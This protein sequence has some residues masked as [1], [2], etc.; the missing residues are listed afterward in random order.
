MVYRGSCESEGQWLVVGGDIKFTTFHEV[1]EVF[2][3]N[4]YCYKVTIETAVTCL[5]WSELL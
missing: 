5:F 2:D 4:V 1:S 3:C